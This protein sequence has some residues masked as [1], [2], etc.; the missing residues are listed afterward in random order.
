MMTF[1]K[2]GSR[3]LI[4]IGITGA[5]LVALTAGLLTTTQ[6]VP[7]SG[8]VSAIGLG[9]YSNALCTVPLTSIS[10]GSVAP[11]TQ[12]TQTIYLENTGNIA[13]NLT[14]AVNSWVPSNAGTYL[15]LTWSPA[16]STLAAGAITSATLTL[17]ASSGAGALSTFSF[18]VAFTGTQ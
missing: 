18:N 11:G 9:V 16:S 12:V 7:A 6:N 17:A 2:L 15:T 1:I 5:L 10:F 4:A 13:E 3:T 8:N 14:M